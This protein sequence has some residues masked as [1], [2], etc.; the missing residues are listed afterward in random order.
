MKRVILES[1]YAGNVKRHVEYARVAMRDCLFRKESPYASHMLLAATGVL[2]DKIPEERE[3]GLSAGWAWMRC[4][5]V[6]DVVVYA[7]LGVSSGMQRGIDNAKSWGRNVE[8][9]KL[10]GAWA[11]ACSRQDLIQDGGWFGPCGDNLA[12]HQSCPVARDAMRRAKWPCGKPRYP[13]LSQEGG[14]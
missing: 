11:I 14:G 8:V 4:L 10:G 9:R 13:E 1:P 12:H 5:D 7:D 3:L 2:D 6:K